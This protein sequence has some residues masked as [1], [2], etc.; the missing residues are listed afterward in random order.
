MAQIRQVVSEALQATV[1][2]LLPSQQGFTEDL[3]ATNVITPVIDLTPTA[4]GDVLPVDL[5]RAL[6]F[7]SQ[8]AFYNDSAGSVTLAN[9]PGFYRVVA[10]STLEPDGT[11]DAGSYFSLVNGVTTKIIWRHQMRNSSTDF[12]TAVQFDFIVFLATGDSLVQTNATNKG[13]IGGSYRQVA[14][15]NGNIVQPSGFSSS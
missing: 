11:N 12:A 3:Q 14:D 15:V 2:R 6:A 8:T 9:S 1:R 5:S 4:E 13:R 7:G 10:G